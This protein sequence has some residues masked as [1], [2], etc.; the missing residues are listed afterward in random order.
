MVSVVR[1]ED[2]D[3]TGEACAGRWDIIG[4]DHSQ[5]SYVRRDILDRAL[6]LA[7]SAEIDMPTGPRR[8]EFWRELDRIRKL[9]SNE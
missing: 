5:A 3:L 9:V 6:R 7:I 1:N 4:R 8:R 2:G